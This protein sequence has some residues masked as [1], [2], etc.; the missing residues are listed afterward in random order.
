MTLPLPSNERGGKN[1]CE[2]SR[3]RQPKHMK[4]DRQ[5]QE[6]IIIAT[7]VARRFRKK[8]SRMVGSRKEAAP[9]GETYPG[10][11]KRE[12]EKLKQETPPGKRT[13]CRTQGCTGFIVLIVKS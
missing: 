3:V 10:G 11:S 8:I 5:A 12:A 9:V 4:G 6:E 1:H 2:A 13:C 7:Q